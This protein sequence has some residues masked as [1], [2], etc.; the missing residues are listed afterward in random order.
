MK[1][2]L[3]WFKKLNRPEKVL[4]LLGTLILVVIATNSGQPTANLDVSSASDKTQGQQSD[5][6][7]R[8]T[9]KTITET[10]D[11]PFGST[12]VNDSTLDKGKT[13]VT[14]AGV[15]G[16]KTLTYQ[17][18]YSDG[19]ETGKKLLKSEITKQPVAQVTAI[20]TYSPPV[21]KQD[22]D[23]NYSGAC[24]PNV[25]PA[26]VDCA[27]GS[28]NGPYYVQGPVTVVGVDHYHLDGNGDGVGCQN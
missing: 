16:T 11:I 2:S 8:V 17:V 15:N 18:T 22:C 19:R 26:D 14:T 10:Q 9:T 25:Y 23:P 12:T 13:K 1:K 5:P 4:L 7:P 24:V 20:G 21:Q 27:G 6:S 28:G 3:R